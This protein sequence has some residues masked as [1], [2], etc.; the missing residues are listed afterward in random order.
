MSDRTQIAN[1]H[2]RI[3]AQK[4]LLRA[5]LCPFGHETNVFKHASTGFRNAV[6]LRR[7]NGPRS[8]L[9]PPRAI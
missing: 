6:A 9:P 8:R 5:V 4:D 7:A 1:E 3:E 2:S